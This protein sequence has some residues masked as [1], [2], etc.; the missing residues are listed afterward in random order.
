[1]LARALDWHAAL[2]AH[3]AYHAVK[4]HYDYLGEEAQEGKEEKEMVYAIGTVVVFAIIFAIET[5]AYV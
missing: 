1:M 2:L 5:I 3:E 4:A